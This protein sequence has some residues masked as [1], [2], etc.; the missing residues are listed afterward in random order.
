M[1]KIFVN[2]YNNEYRMIKIARSI[3][4]R[5]SRIRLPEIIKMPSGTIVKYV[6]DKGI[7][8]N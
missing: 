3:F 4:D 5:S 6:P 8:K 7:R 2:G 1:Q